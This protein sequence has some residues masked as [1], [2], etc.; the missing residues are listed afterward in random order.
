MGKSRK[1]YDDMMPHQVWQLVYT[2]EIKRFPNGYFKTALRDERIV[3]IVKY[4]IEDYM[5]WSEEDVLEKLN[6]QF[7]KDMKLVGMFMER[8]KSIY[9]MLNFVYPGK[10]YPWDL[11]C[12]PNGLW[13]NKETIAMG[14]KYLIEEKLH[15]TKEDVKKYFCQDTL[16]NNGFSGLLTSDVIKGSPYRCLCITYGDDYLKPW[17]LN[18]TPSSYW[19]KE[20]AKEPLYWLI[21]DKGWS[22]EDLLNL[23][24]D[25]IKDLGFQSAY[26]NVFKENIVSLLNNAFPNEYKRVGSSIYHIPS[27][28]KRETKYTSNSSGKTGVGYSTI[29][30]RW[31]AY[32][33]ANGKSVILG[34]FDNKED[35]IKC[36]LEYEKEQLKK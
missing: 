5:H 31:S 11:K 30:N 22:K 24:E 29:R 13:L 26:T 8:F 33:H 28:A 7:L 3:E 17:E 25:A 10:Y 36:R 34:Y 9:D 4:I 21:N 27:G 12:A 16:K 19:N 23:T 6:A 20:T 1:N 14:T 18:Y 2:G 15:W 32:Y 35:A